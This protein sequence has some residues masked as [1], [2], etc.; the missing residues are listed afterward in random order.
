[1]V[2]YCSFHVHG[3]SDPFVIKKLGDTPR[4]RENG[5]SL[6]L[7]APLVAARNYMPPANHIGSPRRVF[8]SFLSPLFSFLFSPPP[9]DSYGH[10]SLSIAES[11]RQVVKEGAAS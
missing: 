9:L 10:H 4:R 7:L 1:M 11:A 2:P 3:G 6:L 8:V 5:R